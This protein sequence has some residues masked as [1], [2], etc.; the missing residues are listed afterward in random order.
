VR[1]IFQIWAK[2]GYKYIAEDDGQG[3]STERI[4]EAALKKGFITPEKAQTL[5]S[6]QVFSLL[7]QA[8]LFHRGECHQGCGPRRRHESDGRPDAADR[9]QGGGCHGRGKF[10]R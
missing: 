9:R 3:L 5:D 10:T 8:G 6:K 4:K 7:F 2:R 1:L